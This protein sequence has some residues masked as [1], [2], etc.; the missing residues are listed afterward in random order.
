MSETPREPGGPYRPI[1]A[2]Q[3]GQDA[4]S[5]YDAII[6]DVG[7]DEMIT[8]SGPLANPREV[9]RIMDELRTKRAQRLA[10]ADDA[11]KAI[12]KRW[13]D[14][15]EPMY[16]KRYV[17]GPLTGDLTI[18]VR[19]PALREALTAEMNLGAGPE[20][21]GTFTAMS[22]AGMVYG[23]FS[24]SLEAGE[25]GSCHICDLLEISYVEYQSEMQALGYWV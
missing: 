25:P 14:G 16:F 13:T 7:G 22:L 17:N 1:G 21:I 19:A 24:S 12:F 5:P 18:Y 10:A 3:R 20:E 9:A 8:L 11:T 2:D 6:L 15:R 23:T 4:E